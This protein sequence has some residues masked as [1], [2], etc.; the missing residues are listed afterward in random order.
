M[1]HYETILLSWFKQP[2]YL[3]VRNVNS[4][5]PLLALA[6]QAYFYRA[7]ALLLFGWGLF[8]LLLSSSA[9][10]MQRTLNTLHLA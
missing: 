9:S 3:A 10:F 8:H 2:W 6:E 7:E 1:W 5:F 4:T